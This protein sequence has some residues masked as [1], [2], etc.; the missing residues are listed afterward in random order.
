MPETFFSKCLPLA[1]QGFDNCAGLTMCNLSPTTADELEDIYKDSTGRFRQMGAM[2]ETDIM[3]RACQVEE[4]PLYTLI[5]AYAKNWDAKKYVSIEKDV[6]SGLALVRPFIRVSRDN[7]I[8]NN[9]WSWTK[10]GDSG[11]S[12][13]TTYDMVGTVTSTTSIP[14]DVNWF[15]ARLVVHIS[16]RSGGGSATKTQWEVKKSVVSG[17]NVILYLRSLN[18]GSTLPGAKLE[19]A[20]TGILVRGMNSISDYESHCDQIPRLNTRSAFLAFMQ[21]S[22]WSICEDEM[23]VRFKKHLFDNNPLYR[24]YFHTDEAQFNGELIKD[25]QNRFVHQFLFGKADPRQT[26]TDW[27]DLDVIESFIDDNTGNSLYIP[28]IEGR[29]VGRRAYVKGVYEQLAECSRVVDLQGDVIN[30]P[31]LQTMLYDMYRVRKANKTP[32][33]EIIEVVVDSAYRVQFVQGLIRYLKMRYEDTL[34]FNANIGEQKKSPALGFMYQD[35]PLDYP[36]G[37]TLRVT[38]HIALDDWVS[39]H[40]TLGGDTL[41]GAARWMMILDWSSIYMAPLASNTKVLKTGSIEDLA[42]INAEALCRMAVPAKSVR[43]HSMLWTAVVECPASSLWIENF[44]FGVPEHEN[45]YGNYSDLRGN[46]PAND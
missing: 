44:S 39:A 19:S 28:G 21:N 22:R 2:L 5:R 38:S 14:A 3:A 9:Y 46:D 43:H 26:E 36:A 41:G 11:T 18:A 4:N 32:N 37:V 10:T 33:P 8:N 42:K 7:L 35:F 30:I 13:G 34:R 27:P 25:W 20:A 12:G 23:T 31:E 16:G 40:A 1:R 15:P 24:E 29:C 6:R 45:K 17:S